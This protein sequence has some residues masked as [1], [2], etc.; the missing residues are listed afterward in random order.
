LPNS[1]RHA[2]LDAITRANAKPQYANG[3][4]SRFIWCGMWLS[5]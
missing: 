2:G 5:G 1:R 4:E 3:D